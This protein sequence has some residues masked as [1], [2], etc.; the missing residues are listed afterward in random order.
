[1]PLTD[2]KG[3]VGKLLRVDLTS[4]KTSEIHIDNAFAENWMGGRGFI[5][6]ILYDELPA[7]ADPFGPENRLIFMTGP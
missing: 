2:Y 3:Y 7:G 5:A 6:K 4:G 1:M